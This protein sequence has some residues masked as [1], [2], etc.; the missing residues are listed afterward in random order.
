[1]LLAY[2]VARPGQRKAPAGLKS[3][4]HESLQCYFADRTEPISELQQEAVDFF[5]KNQQ[6]FA[7]TDLI[8]FRFPTQLN[9]I[10]ELEGFLSTHA[11]RLDG[12]LARLAGMAQVAVYPS[13]SDSG[14][15]QRGSGTEYLRGKAGE[16]QFRRDR[17]R[18]LSAMGGNIV[19]DALDQGERLIF[20][21]PRDRA[22]TW[23]DEVTR[24]PRYRAAG[25]FPP[26]SFAK[27]L[28]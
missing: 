11:S 24:D 15:A 4:L 9:N 14:K 12:E 26:S 20:L 19:R 5:H 13:K 17:L 10:K 21:L 23:M 2:C 25:P 8:E 1:M 16:G 18:E 22:T 3:I 7:Q 28:S 27:L 6:L